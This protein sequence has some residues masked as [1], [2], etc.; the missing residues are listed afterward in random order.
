[1][2]RVFLEPVIAGD[3]AHDTAHIAA[4][5]VQV[6]DRKPILYETADQFLLAL[7]DNLQK[8]AIVLLK[9]AIGSRRRAIQAML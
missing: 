7:S 9:I 2:N 4:D 6:S 1:M 5:V 8:I 3:D